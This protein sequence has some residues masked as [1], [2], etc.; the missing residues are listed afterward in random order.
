MDPRPKSSFGPTLVRGA[1]WAAAV[2]LV[3][4]AVRYWFGYFILA[5]G[6]TAGAFISWGFLAWVRSRGGAPPR[7]DFKTTLSVAL[8]WF[9]LFMIGQA[10]GLG[11]AQP[12]FDP[13]GW[14][15]RVWSG[16]SSEF[17]FGVAA[18]AAVARGFAGGVHGWFWLILS[19]IDWWIMIMMLLIIPWSPGG[20]GKAAKPAGAEVES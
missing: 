13:L 15:G 17:V 20:S 8:I 12:W 2:G 18:N 16:K 19:L 3:Y 10:I 5:Q 9:G 4:G 7:P 14:V 1:V 6:A 11:L